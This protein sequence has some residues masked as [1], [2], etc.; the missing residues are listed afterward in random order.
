MPRVERA[1]NNDFNEYMEFIANHPNYEGLPIKRKNDG[2]LSW[3]VFGNSAEGKARKKWAEE[4][5]K[6]LGHPIQH[7]VYAE[8]MREIHPTK[9]HLCQICGSEM[10]IY[11]L[12]PSTNLVKALLKTFGVEFSDCEYISDIWDKLLANG[13]DLDDVCKFFIQKLDLSLKATATKDEIIEAG[14]KRCRIDGKK[15]FSPGAM[16]NFPD[17]FDG[18][19]TY[20]RCCRE[21]QDTGRSKENLKSYTKD[22][23]AYELWCD[24]NIHAANT[25]MGSKRFSGQSADHIGP[26]S[27][28]F[29]H[30]PRYLRPMSGSDNSAKRDR[31]SESDIEAIIAVEDATGVPPMSWYSSRLWEFIRKNYKLNPNRIESYRL[32]LKQSVLNYLFVLKLIVDT[33]GDLGSDFLIQTIIKPKYADFLYAYKFDNNG[34]ITK[35]TPRSFTER[36]KYEMERFT[37]IAIE[38][39]RDFENKENRRSTNCVSENEKAEVVAL[40]K[41]LTADRFESAYRKLKS[42]VCGIEERL[43]QVMSSE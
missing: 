5:A 25:Y 37:R 29:V 21:A 13:F 24:G 10:S 7:G 1:W 43:L 19:H 42:I 23:R 14:E 8:V 17:R 40:S 30:D 2:T 27:L 12:Y 28:G 11:Y 22:R 20:N 38:A 18:F 26:I 15:Q 36:S 35:Q 41:N 3:I 9:I 6:T 33:A 4:K 32:V 31:L 34:N 39:L 16:S